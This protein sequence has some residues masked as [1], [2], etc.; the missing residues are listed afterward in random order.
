MTVLKNFYMACFVEHFT[1]II[2]VK[3]S[4]F[5]VEKWR[6]YRQNTKSPKTG[7]VL[8]ILLSYLQ[9]MDKVECSYYIDCISFFR[10]KMEFLSP[11]WAAWKALQNRLCENFFKTEVVSWLSA[12]E[13]T[14]MFRKNGL[15]LK[16]FR[17]NNYHIF[18]T[19]TLSRARLAF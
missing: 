6:R 1:L 16:L 3:R 19:N 2:L 17:M 8:K 14:E 10:R 18:S 12:H 9:V 15:E 13:K 7:Q 4:P 5:F 11:K